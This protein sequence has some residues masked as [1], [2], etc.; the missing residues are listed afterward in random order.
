MTDYFLLIGILIQQFFIAVLL[1]VWMKSFFYKNYEE[2]N[3]ILTLLD[4]NIELLC[5]L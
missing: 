1:V 4:D 3:G 2:N 5:S